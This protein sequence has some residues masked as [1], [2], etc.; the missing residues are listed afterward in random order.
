MLDATLLPPYLQI[1]NSNIQT[2]DL[3][4]N[5]IG[6]EGATAIA[7]SLANNTKLKRL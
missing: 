5:Q 2:L 3:D 1:L 6:N 7:N 4:E